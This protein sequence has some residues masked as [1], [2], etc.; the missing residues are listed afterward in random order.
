M[1]TFLLT[2]LTYRHSK[3]RPASSPK[4]P[5]KITQLRANRQESRKVGLLLCHFSLNS[6][7]ISKS[8][9]SVLSLGPRPTG[10]GSSP[11]EL[12]HPRA[13]PQGLPDLP[14]RPPIICSSS[15]PIQPHKARPKREPPHN[16]RTGAPGASKATVPSGGPLSDS[17]WQR[18]IVEVRAH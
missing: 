3:T 9:E 7:G 10:G 16:H 5:C 11:P 13:M 15:Q 6:K 2:H 12:R 1:L 14:P 8:L 18:K 4:Y 17:E